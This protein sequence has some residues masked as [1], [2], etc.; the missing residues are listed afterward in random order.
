MP[1]PAA[2]SGKAGALQAW[3]RSSTAAW[4]VLGLL[5]VATAALLVHETRGTTLWFDDWEYALARPANE[6][7]TYLE[8][9]GEHLSLIPIAIYKLLLATA[10]MDHYLPYRLLVIALH[11]ACVVLVFAYAKRRV[12]GLFALLVATLLLTLGPGWQNFLWPFQIAWLISLAACLGAL[13]LLDRRDRAGD[14]L[15][16]LLLGVALASS[17]LGL[18]IA[19]GL[20]VDVGWGRRR[21]RDAWIV[22]APLALYVP[23]WLVYRPA[24]VERHQLTLVLDFATDSA[25]GVMNALTGLTHAPLGGPA[26]TL[27]WGLPLAVAAVALLVWRLAALRP[28]PP[29]VWTLLTILVSF[30]VLTGLRRAGLAVGNESRYVYVGV[31]FTLLLVV[32]LARGAELP[33]RALPAV[34]V[35]VAAVAIANLGDL[36]DA[37]RF[38]RG[39]ADITRADLGAL[40]LGR[41]LVGPDYVATR[42]TGYPFVIVHAGQYFAAADRHGTPAATPAQIAAAPEPARMVADAELTD[43][44]RVALRPATAARP[45]GPVPEV[46][47]ASGGTTS[48]RDGCVSFAPLPVTPAASVPTLDLTVPRTGL[49]LA[50][51]GAPLTATLRRFATGFGAQPLARVAAGATATLR[52]GGD[53][54]PQPWHVR[55]APAGR[56]TACGLPGA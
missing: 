41:R 3:R 25:A 56:V 18:P 49:W 17:G 22:A 5:L 33:R 28:V 13:M 24:S 34:V 51:E 27:D 40:E 19:A 37:G 30:W 32:E 45:A 8:P 42:M 26:A 11:L 4:A 52:I 20:A 44:H 9:H 46:D 7:H 6:V 23:W 10:G 12:G 21:L 2:V 39:A 14:V 1:T 50:A 16:S 36:R 38:L 29:R 48:L 43:I 47:A 15:A 54:A 53:A 55:V 31:F 35:A